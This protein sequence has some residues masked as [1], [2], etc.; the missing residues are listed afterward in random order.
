MPDFDEYQPPALDDIDLPVAD[1]NWD[2]RTP[3]NSEAELRELIDAG[4]TSQMARDLG[5]PPPLAA[6][7]VTRLPWPDLPAD[8]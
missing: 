8:A 5:F 6:D 4:I 1:D 2:S 7:G 3:M